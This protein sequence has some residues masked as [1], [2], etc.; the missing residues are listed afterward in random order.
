MKYLEKTA[1]QSY[2]DQR[3]GESKPAHARRMAH[4]SGK[5]KLSAEE[6]RRDVKQK[7]DNLKVKNSMQ[8]KNQILGS[9]IILSP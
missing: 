7:R 8:S 2:K 5:D 3:P 6:I 9:S 1:Q 4:I